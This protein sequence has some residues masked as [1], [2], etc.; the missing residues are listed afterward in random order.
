MPIVKN[1]AIQIHIVNAV[2]RLI[3][4]SSCSVF[5]LWVFLTSQILVKE[6]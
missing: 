3:L 1:Y 2:M 4:M 5:S 6:Q